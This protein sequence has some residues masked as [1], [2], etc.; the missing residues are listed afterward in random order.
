[1]KIFLNKLN[2]IIDYYIVYFLYD[3]NKIDRYHDYMRN[4]WVKN[5]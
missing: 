4:K 3:V 5:I 2:W 1:M